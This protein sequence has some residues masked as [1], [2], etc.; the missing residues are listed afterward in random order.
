MMNAPAKPKPNGAVVL[1][2]QRFRDAHDE[3]A[4]QELPHD[5]KVDRANDGDFVVNRRRGGGIPPG[6]AVAKAGHATD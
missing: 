3:V 6:Q 4:K 2:G 1:V 5:I